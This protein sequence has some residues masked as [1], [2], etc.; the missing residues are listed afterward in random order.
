MSSA[1]LI[2]TRDEH[3]GGVCPDVEQ[4]GAGQP[5]QQSRFAMEVTSAVRAVGHTRRSQ[6]AVWVTN[7]VSSA[8]DRTA[9]ASFGDGPDDDTR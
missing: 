9:V 1:L 2:S 5:R 3:C 6:A 7:F 8:K 4:C